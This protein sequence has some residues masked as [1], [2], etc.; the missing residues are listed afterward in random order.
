M[1]SSSS[2]SS[3]SEESQPLLSSAS[4]VRSSEARSKLDLLSSLLLLSGIVTF[5]GSTLWIV[6]GE[7]K[8][9]RG[10]LWFSLHPTFQ[11]FAI[12]G[13]VLAIWALQP[14]S[15]TAPKE[16]AQA[17]KAHRSL[18]LS[19]VLPSI[20]LGS[21][22]MYYN[23]S[24]H[25]AKHFTTWHGILGATTLLYLFVQSLFGLVV[26]TKPLYNVLGGKAKAKSFF[27]HH[28]AS[29]YVVLPLMLFTAHLGGAHSTWALGSAGF[30]WRVAAYWVGLPMIVAGLA[31][32]VRAGK[33]K[34]L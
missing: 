25:G 28:R 9:P 34:F 30:G 16:K 21:S 14:T 8:D 29:G 13:V 10:N 17:F 31:L 26:S 22:A 6:W 32:R 20:I 3:R 33:M 7:Q 4:S 19:L 12:A 5:V 2:S 24:S 18:V 11:S 27:K 23:K 15:T 1:V